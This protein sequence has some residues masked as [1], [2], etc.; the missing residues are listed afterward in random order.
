[1]LDQETM[2]QTLT[3]RWFDDFFVGERFALPSRVLTSEVLRAFAE[4]SG[5]AQGL[6]SNP[7]D[8]RAIGYDCVLAHGFL[9]TIQT[10][11]CPGVFPFLVEDSLVG[12]LEQSS[13]YVRPVAEGDTLSPML[14]V[15]ELEPNS[16]GTGIV[17]LR[18]TVHNQA[19]ALIVEGAQRWLMRTRP[20]H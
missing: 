18:S 12:L 5:D 20:K 11:A 3:T 19:R 16:G 7:A 2:R 1:L 8:S 4:A 13:R 17:G 15:V 10:V 6:R 9:A 14:Q